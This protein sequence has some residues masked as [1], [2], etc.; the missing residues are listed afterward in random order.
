MSNR[1]NGCRGCGGRGR[2]TN[3]IQCGNGNGN[4][5]NPC[6]TRPIVAVDA[7]CTPP[8]GSGT[9]SII[10]F[11]SG[12]ILSP[13]GNYYCRVSLVHLASSDS[14]HPFLVLTAL[15]N[16]I[17]LGTLPSEAFSVPRAG[18]ITAISAALE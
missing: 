13:T 12:I 15:G 2:C 6:I 11:C 5:V 8:T 9:G 17:N 7:S 10:P 16:T 3:N 18:S 4:G 1:N 14:V